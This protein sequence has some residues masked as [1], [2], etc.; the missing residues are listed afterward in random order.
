MNR[1]I[2]MKI[3]ILSGL[4]VVFLSHWHDLAALMTVL[5]MLAVIPLWVLSYEEIFKFYSERIII[6]QHFE[7][8]RLY[9]KQ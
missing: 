8:K 2:L 1:K 6:D 3:T 5:V 9:M 7:G 4:L